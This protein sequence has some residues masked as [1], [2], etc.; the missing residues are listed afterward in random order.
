MHD[1]RGVKM[2]KGR[3]Q[4]SYERSCGRLRQPLLLEIIPHVRQQLTALSNLRHQAVEVAGLHGLVES[5]DVRVAKT[6]HELSLTEQVFTNIF[7]LDLICLYYLYC[8]L[9][10]E[11]R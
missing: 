6:P 3:D 2:M 5:D 1:T 4:L 10:Q 7:L 8:N 9:G 11:R